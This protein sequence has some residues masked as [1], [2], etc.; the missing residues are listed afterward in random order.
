MSRIDSLDL[1]IA[2]LEGKSKK[3]IEFN[4][5]IINKIDSWQKCVAYIVMCVCK[6]ISIIHFMKMIVTGKLN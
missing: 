6:C 5:K 4:G 3:L 1:R 2:E